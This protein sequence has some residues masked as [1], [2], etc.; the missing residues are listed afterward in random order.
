MLA[1]V[2][3]CT[4]LAE[5]KWISLHG[6]GCMVDNQPLHHLGTN[7]F[8]YPGKFLKEERDFTDNTISHVEYQFGSNIKDS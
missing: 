2:L 1:I 4:S 7:Q 6:G 8:F 5:P 3:L